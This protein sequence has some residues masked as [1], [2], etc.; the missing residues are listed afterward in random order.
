VWLA[1]RLGARRLILLKRGSSPPYGNAAA[2]AKAGVMDPLAPAF[3]ARLP[4]L[5]AWIAAPHGVSA[6]RRV[7]ADSCAAPG[8]KLLP[9]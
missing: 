8:R 1:R 5:E 3:L 2:L 4:D 7:L 9:A 6:L